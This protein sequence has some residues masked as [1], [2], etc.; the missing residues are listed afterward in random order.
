MDP[1]AVDRTGGII[2][3][4]MVV[5]ECQLIAHV[6]E[7]DATEGERQSVEHQQASDPE[8]QR[9]EVTR[10]TCVVD[11]DERR[12]RS[13]RALV[14][15]VVVGGER[16]A[17]RIAGGERSPVE[18]GEKPSVGTSGQPDPRGIF[19]GHRPTDVIVTA[20]VGAPRGPGGDLRHASKRL[21]GE[22]HVLLGQRR[23]PH[24]HELVVIGEFALATLTRPVC[25]EI[26]HE[27]V[28][29]DDG[30]RLHDRRRRGHA[31]HGPEHLGDEMSL[32]LVL[33]VRSDPLPGEGHGIEAQHVD[34]QVGEEAH[35][36]EHLDED[37]GIGV[38][39]VPLECVER[40]PHPSTHRVVPGEIARCHR[41]EHFGKAALPAVGLDPVRIGE[42]V[43]ALC[44]VSRHR[45][46]SPRVGVGGVVHHEIDAHR[47][48]PFVEFVDEPA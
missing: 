2:G 12:R 10:A 28:G 43:R 25:T 11:P 45:F 37:V 13:A 9:D 42:K 4:P 17:G 18:L 14:A 31:Q 1:S 30:L 21:G 32:R 15:G 48:L 36:I 39:Q 47:H 3:V 44:F 29:S 27:I 40:R 35:D 46:E 26:M 33:T 20:H 6:D 23:P 16:D 41:R 34:A 38:V 7:R 8:I 19:V 24:H 22:P 5:G